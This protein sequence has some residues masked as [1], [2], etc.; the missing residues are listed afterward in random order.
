MIDYC[1]YVD[2]IR[3]VI[4][5]PKLTKEF[6]LKTL[7]EQV[8]KAANIFIRS[9]KLNLK[10]NTAK[11]KVIPYRGKPKGISSETDNLQE[12]SSE[13]LGPE[14]L[15]NLISELETLLV[16]S[17][18]ESTDQD[19]CKHNHTH[20][21]NKLADIE[22]STFDVREDT[23]RRF[24]ANK[25]A[26]ALK[27]KRHFTSREVNEQG[28]PIAGEW[29]YFQER[30]A[31]RLIAVWS[32][33]PALV[34][35]LKKGLELFPSPKVLEPVLEQF[36]T[37]KQRQD[38]KQTAIMNYCL[39]E[40]FRHSATTI[41]KKDPQAIPAQADV[42]NYFE[43]LQNK[44]VSLVTTS[45][46]NTDEWNF[47]AE[48]ARFLLLVR[49]DTA[50]E[51]PVGDIKQDLIFKLAKGFRNITLPEKLKQK[52]IS[53]CILLANQLLENNQ[54]L[55]RAALE[56]IAK[57]NILTAIA[58]QN[59]ELAGQ[60]IKQ[61]RLLKAE[62]NWVF[63][64]EIKD[65]ADKIYLDIAPS[66]K[67]LE[68]ITTKQSLVQLFIRPDNPFASE[69]M[70]IK[71]MQ[72]LIEKVN[73]NP[74]KLVG[75]QINLAA[76]QVEFDTGYSEIPKYQDFDTLLKV[77]QLE[78][79]QALSSDFLETKKLSSTEQP[80]ALSV[81]QLALRKV[82]FVIRAALA[83]S[84]D[85]TGFGVSISPKAGYRGLKSTLAKRQIGLYTTPESLAG[86]GA[87]TS[88]WLTTL[89]TK[90]LR[91]PGIRAN[92]QG[93]KWPEILGINDV[94]KLLKE[95]LELLKTNYCQLSQMPTLPELVSP[96]WEE[97][98]TDLN[99]VMVQSKLPKQADFS[100][101]LYL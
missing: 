71:L 78:T 85:T 75:Q 95:R 83:S 72:A 70:A 79:Q 52:D 73:A 86:E 1:R 11:T 97:S 34:L 51:S 2:D 28:N 15:D 17:T 18:A 54:P 101:D 35:L 3:L 25:L 99:V 41:H 61:A 96:H 36:E 90:L 91:W 46:Q 30:I 56:L 58:T 57:Q 23:L 49:M 64:D 77:T 94:E 42:N 4:T 53:L 59:P 81:E 60:L 5:A 21:R 82:A 100:G 7:T 80:P 47:L 76:T 69:I 31:R 62:Y 63:T 19:A 33:D 88:G 93:Y 43:V 92:E 27:L 50:L 29:D 84:K 38:K 12:R 32:K 39:A 22:R 37:V 24:A 65:L 67:P 8:A 13:P 66:R 10:I 20:K 55:L 26:K 14:Q 98:K 45:E 89:L 44:A 6:T 87:Q 68:K 16:L 40:V 9:K 48:Q 74:A